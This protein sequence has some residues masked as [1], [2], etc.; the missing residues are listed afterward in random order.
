MHLAKLEVRIVLEEL[1][2]RIT[3]ITAVG[4][5]SWTRSN[6]ICG[7]KKLDVKVEVKS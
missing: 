6:F 3:S 5:A 2:K 1:A 7:V 4:E